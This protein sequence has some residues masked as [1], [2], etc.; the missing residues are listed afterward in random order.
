MKRPRRVEVGPFRFRV[1]WSRKATHAAACADGDL[2]LG[3]CSHRTETITVDPDQTP[4][5]QRDTLLHECLHA[6]LG[7]SG[8]QLE[9]DEEERLVRTLS[10]LLLD[11]LRRN[12]TLVRF[13]LEE[14]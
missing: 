8:A 14:P 4:G 11:L 2:V 1:R 3:S 9:D 10:P 5:M 6:V 13:L 7:N 12:P